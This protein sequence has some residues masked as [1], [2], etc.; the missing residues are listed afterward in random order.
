MTYRLVI[1][2]LPTMP[3]PYKSK[4]KILSNRPW[5]KRVI[6]KSDLWEEK[7]DLWEEKSD[8]WKQFRFSL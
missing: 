2:E 5:L 3:H 8:L 6:K 7:S 4:G 1:K